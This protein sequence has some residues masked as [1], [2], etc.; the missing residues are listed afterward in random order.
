MHQTTAEVAYIVHNSEA[1]G[2]DAAE[3]RSALHDYFYLSYSL[4]GKK[5][6]KTKTMTS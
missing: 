5:R 3:D 6:N 1:L 2:S 4:E